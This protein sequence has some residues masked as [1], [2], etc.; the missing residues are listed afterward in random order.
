MLYPSYFLFAKTKCIETFL[1]S[2]SSHDFVVLDFWISCPFQST[3]PLK[4]EG[5]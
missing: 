3:S 5:R 4:L 2:A 1:V